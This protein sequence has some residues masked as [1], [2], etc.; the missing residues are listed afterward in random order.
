MH[1]F[2]RYKTWIIK[3]IF[4]G[5]HR[6]CSVR[7]GV[8]RNFA[9]LTGNTCATVSCQRLAHVFSSEF[10][11]ISRNT[12]FIKHFRAT[13][14]AYSGDFTVGRNWFDLAIVPGTKEARG[15]LQLRASVD[16]SFLRKYPTVR[17]NF[18][19]SIKFSLLLNLRKFL[20]NLKYSTY[21]GLDIIKVMKKQSTVID[22]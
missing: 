15:N 16:R 11:K 8:L 6:R 17:R 12:F 2:L 4:R 14:S 9:N 1:W 20:R 5:S 21:F 18:S 10:R 22:K 7:K 19:C 13:V 3:S